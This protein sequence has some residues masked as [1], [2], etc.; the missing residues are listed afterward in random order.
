MPTAW[1]GRKRCFRWI[2][3]LCC[4]WPFRET[5]SQPPFPSSIEPQRKPRDRQPQRAG[6]AALQRREKGN[7]NYK[8]KTVHDN[9]SHFCSMPRC[10]R[11][12]YLC[13]YTP[14]FAS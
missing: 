12:F 14:Y 5:R 9:S 1:R 13:T 11:C 2:L 6:R 8:W 4:P 3:V 10:L 7:R